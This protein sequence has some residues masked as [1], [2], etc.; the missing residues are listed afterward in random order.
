[1]NQEKPQHFI[2]SKFGTPTLGEMV[3][4]LEFRYS[5]LDDFEVFE[6]VFL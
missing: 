2:T 4:V 6:Y 3:E 5:F 1:M